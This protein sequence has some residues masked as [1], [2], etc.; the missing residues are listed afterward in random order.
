MMASL[1]LYLPYCIGRVLPYSIASI[2]SIVK[3]TNTKP[4]NL[5]YN[6]KH[7]LVTFPHCCMHSCSF[8][9]TASGYFQWMIII[10]ILSCTRYIAFCNDVWKEIQI[11][12]PVL[13][14][15]TSSLLLCYHCHG[16]NAFF[17]TTSTGTVPSGFTC[18]NQL[19]FPY[20]EYAEHKFLRNVFI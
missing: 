3:S 11:G 4:Y 15:S 16:F 5:L 12:Y 13:T 10:M 18:Q 20:M 2:R 8:V 14:T 1:H 7:A 19:I 17:F 6:G 9:L